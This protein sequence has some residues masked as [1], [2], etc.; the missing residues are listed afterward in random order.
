VT[1]T[2]YAFDISNAGWAA[3]LML[4]HKRIDY[5]YR[6]L[7]PGLHLQIVRALGFPAATVPA[8]RIDGRKLQGSRQISRALE[9]IVPEPPLFPAEPAARVAVEDAER[10][11][12]EQLQDVPRF[13]LRLSGLRSQA[14]RRFQAE[15]AGLPLPGVAAALGKVSAWDLA[16]RRDVDEAAVR[17]VINELPE[18]IARI[19]ALIAAGVI[20]TDQPNA[21]DFQIAPSVRL[22][23]AIEGVA[24]AIEDSD[25]AA[26]AREL[27]PELVPGGPIPWVLPPE[28]LAPLRASMGSG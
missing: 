19:D 4:D 7:P 25:A 28:W 20:G 27:V 11:G 16:R 26:H 1:A 14:N 17:R 15:R 21:A 24:D 22:L 13:I 12:D 18:T 10:W 9:E 23:L 8:L 5:R 6:K 3:R 2:L